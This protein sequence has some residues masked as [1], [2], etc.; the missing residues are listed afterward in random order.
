MSLGP[1]IHSLSVI[2]CPQ[3]NCRRSLTPS[4][5]SF[6][7][8]PLQ[9]YI[10]PQLTLIHSINYLEHGTVMSASCANSEGIHISS[11]LDLNN[12]IANVNRQLYCQ[13]GGNFGATC[14]SVAD[15]DSKTADLYFDCGTGKTYEFLF[16]D[17]SKC[18]IKIRIVMLSF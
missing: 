5:L 18:D 9:W 7:F 10:N 11:T 1:P 15:F 2:T 17:V 13:D 4:Y 3:A 12:C 8:T 14:Q 16:F 6:H